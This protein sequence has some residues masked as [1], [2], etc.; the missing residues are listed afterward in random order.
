MLIPKIQRHEL[1]DYFKTYSTQ[2]KI[3]KQNRNKET[4]S[5]MSIIMKN[6]KLTDYRICYS[7]K[8]QGYAD[9]NYAAG[10]C[11]KY[12]GE[13]VKNN[14]KLGIKTMSNKG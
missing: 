12:Y 10:I 3:E 13:W 2:L 14:F 7:P 1:K 6:Q 8:L 5:M 4:Q 11:F 9:V